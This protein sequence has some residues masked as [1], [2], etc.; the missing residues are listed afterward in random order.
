MDN[1]FCYCCCSL[2]K[3]PALGGGNL[4]LIPWISRDWN[5]LVLLSAK[6]LAGANSENFCLW[7]LLF[8]RGYLD[9]FPQWVSCVLWECIFLLVDIRSICKLCR[10]QTSSLCSR[11]KSDLSQWR[12]GIRNCNEVYQ[13][14][15]YSLK[16]QSQTFYWKNT[17]E[18]QVTAAMLFA[19]QV[20]IYK[21]ISHEDKK[22]SI[23][24]CITLWKAPTLKL[25]SHQ[26]LLT[27]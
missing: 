21:C 1:F 16:L 13:G 19:M 22:T 23:S 15:N 27:C 26:S 2:F 9:I 14:L 6:Y 7:H 18:N 5:R 3:I 24:Y 12:P 8:L 25:A 10:L 17:L 20:R 4:P 11:D